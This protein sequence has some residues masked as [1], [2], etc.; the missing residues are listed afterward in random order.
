MLLRQPAVRSFA[1]FAASPASLHAKSSAGAVRCKA[2]QA[3][4][5]TGVPATSIMVAAMRAV[6]TELPEAERRLND[7][8][9]RLFVNESGI[10][11]MRALD[12]AMAADAK[13]IRVVFKKP[14]DTVAQRNFAAIRC[15]AIDDVVRKIL[16]ELPSIQQIV[17]LGSGMD[18][19]AYRLDIPKSVTMYELDYPRVLAYK[20]QTLE[21]VG[22]EPTCKRIEIGTDM[23]VE[24]WAEKL[25]DAGFDT[26]TPTMWIAEGLLYY[27]PK[28]GLLELLARVDGLSRSQSRFVF[29]TYDDHR[30]FAGLP[31]LKEFHDKRGISYHN[32]TSDTTQ[33]LEV[34]RWE[35]VTSHAAPFM[36]KHVWKKP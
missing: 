11:L 24:D 5:I 19:R 26:M 18:T 34:Y 35:Q 29:D 31:A 13:V 3:S 27:I 25:L 7:P 33:P 12:E 1:R 21:L 6:E 4:G 22:A 20:T 28:Q 16:R 32:S 23:A 8:F 30:V 14:A 17:L 36:V 15:A 10:R 2:T 9:A